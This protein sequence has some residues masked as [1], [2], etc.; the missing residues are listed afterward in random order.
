MLMS[1]LLTERS[2]S[3]QGLTYLRRRMGRLLTPHVVWALVP[4][5]IYVL[6]YKFFRIQ[7]ANVR[8]LSVVGL[9]LLTGSTTINNVMWYMVD[10]IALT[11]I[12]AALYSAIKSE[13]GR[14]YAIV[15]LML[16]ALYLQYSSINYRLFNGLP[17]EVFPPVG[18]L[19]E[20]IPYMCIGLLMSRYGWLEKA[21]E[22]WL[23][24]AIITGVMYLMCKRLMFFTEPTTY[25]EM[26][27]V[28]T[29][30]FAYQGLYKLVKAVILVVLFYVVPFHRLSGWIKSAI[31]FVSNYSVGIYCMH[32]LI[33]R[34][35]NAKIFPALG[36][37]TYSF[38]GCLINF[39]ICLLLAFA[40]SKLPGK[41]PKRAV[42]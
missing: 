20:M 21:K 39:G 10:M 16:A 38:S 7:L 1:F 18:R 9:Q 13:T 35:L 3:Q 34:A 25:N 30:G 40:I 6:L 37:A 4:A 36:W 32:R 22:H 5:L 19:M 12:A 26:E 33:G 42:M 27:E 17:S 11:C 31:L 15:L 23:G 24:V 8:S 29:A 2:L 28:I 41:W 14:V